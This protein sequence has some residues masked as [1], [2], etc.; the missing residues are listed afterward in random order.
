MVPLS[1][2]YLVWISY[3]Q[4]QVR[5]MVHFQTADICLLSVSLELLSLA[6]KILRFLVSRL[7]VDRYHWRILWAVLCPGFS[8]LHV[9]LWGCYA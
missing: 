6:H 7:S 3:G 8:N 5:A 2:V 4:E 1:L 9:L